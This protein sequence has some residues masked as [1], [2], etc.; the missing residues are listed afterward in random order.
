[1][2]HNTIFI[3]VKDNNIKLYFQ[4]VQLINLIFIKPVK[5]VKINKL[6][7]YSRHRPEN[8]EAEH[9]H[10][11]MLNLSNTTMKEL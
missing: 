10:S 9:F 2:Q 6:I 11:K 4:S 3:F 1:M 8:E 7:T 5:P